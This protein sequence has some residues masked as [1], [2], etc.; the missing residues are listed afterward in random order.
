VFGPIALQI[1]AGWASAIVSFLVAYVMLLALGIFQTVIA[2]ICL[3]GTLPLA[4]YRGIR[5]F[6]VS[7]DAKA[8]AREWA[9]C[10]VAV[11]VVAA[12][13]TPFLPHCWSLSG[14]CQ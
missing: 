2:I 14:V 10:V 7:G 12:V 5:H 4:I 9:T 13:L 3:P 8:V 6:I 1:A 11:G